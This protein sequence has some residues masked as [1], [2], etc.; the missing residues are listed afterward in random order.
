MFNTRIQSISAHRI[1]LVYAKISLILR[2]RFYIIQINSEVPLL[3]Y[4]LDLVLYLI[5]SPR[6]V[7]RIARF[8]LNRNDQYN[9]LLQYKLI[10]STCAMDIWIFQV[11]CR[12]LNQVNSSS[13]QMQAMCWRFGEGWGLLYNV[14]K[15]QALPE[16]GY[17]YANLTVVFFMN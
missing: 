15:H 17:R 13:Q 11:C 14:Q 4:F 8:N 7:W 9:T 10:T 1:L 3:N 16:K 2:T 6:F 5:L 12:M